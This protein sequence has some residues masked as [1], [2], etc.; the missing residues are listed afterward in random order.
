MVNPKTF[1]LIA[2]AALLAGCGL[3]SITGSGNVITQEEAI[4]GFDKLDISNGFQVDV[5]QGDSFSVVIRIDDN[6]VEH[7]QVTKQGSTLSIGLKPGRS[8]SIRDATLEADVT[9]LELTGLDVSGGS[10]V[11]LNS[12]S[13]AKALDADLSGGSHLTGDLE[14]GDTTINLSGGSHATLGG[15]AGDLTVDASGGSHAK[16]ADLTVADA[17]IDASGGSHATVSPSGRLDA[18]ASGGSHVRYLGSP[19]LGTTD[20]DGSSSIKPE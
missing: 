12:V 20:A 4:T 1:V 14:A 3:G 9:M 2:V 8:Y 6:L 5:S 19:T 15:S 10:R 13:S 11:T 16:L 7:L 18:V 17:D